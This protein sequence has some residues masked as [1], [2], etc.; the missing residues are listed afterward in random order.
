[1]LYIHTRY[2][3][4]IHVSISTFIVS[5]LGASDCTIPN[6]DVCSGNNCTQ[7]SPT[8][9][10]AGFSPTNPCLRCFVAC[11]YCYRGRH[12]EYY[13][14]GDSSCG[15]D[16]YNNFPPNRTILDCTP[17]PQSCYKCPLGYFH[18]HK[19]GSNCY[20]CLHS[21]CKCTEADNCP[22]CIDGKY[23]AT[24]FCQDTCPRNCVNCT[25]KTH[26][27]ACVHGKY[28][29]SCESDC[30]NTCADGSCDKMLGTCTNC[31]FGKYPDTNNPFGMT[32]C[33]DCPTRC[34]GCVNLHNCT[35]CTSQDYWGTTCQH[36]CTGCEGLCSV[37]GCSY[38]CQGGY[39]QQFSTAKKGY[40]CQKCQP[41][42]RTCTSWMSCQTCSR[43]FWGDRC[44]YSCTGCSSDCDSHGCT[45]GCV[46]GY[47]RH[48]TQG[49][50][51]CSQCPYHGYLAVD[52]VGCVP[53]SAISG[54]TCTF[55]G[56]GNGSSPIYDRTANILKCSEA[57][58]VG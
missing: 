27:G 28:G 43:G 45:S 37:D 38:G 47:Y 11:F 53:C 41:T 49:G 22:E 17:Q 29:I 33:K 57:P 13:T 31:P 50:Y 10:N 14:C 32:F 9:F 19:L 36:N 46:R 20:K 21:N 44:Q 30:I 40:E 18:D 3:I 5:D 8:F 1:M 23:N 6:C 58:L 4:Y 7:C 48:L 56:C 16:V 51:Q 34:A 26:C 55:G 25:D 24:N 39:Y 35:L 42:C 54:G 15:C 52:D 2:H 12:D